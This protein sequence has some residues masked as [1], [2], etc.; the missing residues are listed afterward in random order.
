MAWDNIEMHRIAIG[1][2][3]AIKWA[4]VHNCKRQFAH[5]YHR[6]RVCLLRNVLSSWPCRGGV[7]K[8]SNSYLVHGALGEGKRANS[9]DQMMVAGFG[10]VVNCLC[11]V[12]DEKRRLHVLPHLARSPLWLKHKWRRT[13]NSVY[14]ARHNE[15]LGLN[16][17]FPHYEASYLRIR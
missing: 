4:P 13:P 16:P 3:S 17:G 14:C 9:T 7:Y 6:V 15:Q 10:G 2:E 5:R 1:K 8:Q 12:V 11:A